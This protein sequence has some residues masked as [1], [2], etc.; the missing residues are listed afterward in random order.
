M[1]IMSVLFRLK[2]T[3]AGVFRV[4]TPSVFVDKVTQPVSVSTRR[5]AQMPDPDE[6]DDKEFLRS[7]EEDP[8]EE[9]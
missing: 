4:F 3:S 7:T 6:E 5:H 9:D 2:R 1:H 8:R